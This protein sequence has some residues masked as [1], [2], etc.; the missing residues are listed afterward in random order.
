MDYNTLTDDE[1]KEVDM[2]NKLTQYECCELQR[3]APSG[4]PWF[5]DSKPF[6]PFFAKRM[7]ETGGFTPSISKSL[8]WG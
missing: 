6:Y 4:H 7:K 3:F 8:G 2:I 1:K 5:D